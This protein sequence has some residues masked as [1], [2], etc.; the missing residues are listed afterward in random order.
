MNTPLES[1]FD[2]IALEIGSSMTAEATQTVI[3]KKTEYWESG[4][5]GIHTAIEYIGAQF[6]EHLVICQRCY[7]DTQQE[8]KLGIHFAKAEEDR[9]AVLKI[10][11]PKDPLLRC[12]YGR[13]LERDRKTK[14]I[15]T[16]LLNGTERVHEI[17]GVSNEYI[18]R[19]V[20]AAC[21]M[22][23]QDVYTH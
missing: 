15:G 13:R 19:L 6:M 11:L 8:D 21:D 3:E 16:H 4:I 12:L 17:S 5:Y 1:I 20:Y 10:E 18:K 2:E 23:P 7:Q 14:P 9:K 22:K